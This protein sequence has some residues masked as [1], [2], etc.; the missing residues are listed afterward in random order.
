MAGQRG[1]AAALYA[2]AEL[3]LAAGAVYAGFVMGTAGG[4]SGAPAAAEMRPIQGGVGLRGGSGGGVAGGAVDSCQ[5]DSDMTAVMG[6]PGD[7]FET[8][9]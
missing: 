6:G 3:L 1:G 8:L 9:C 5:F 4:A 2:A 7:D